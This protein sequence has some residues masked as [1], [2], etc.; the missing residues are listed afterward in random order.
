M[1]Q[2][3]WPTCFP[4]RLLVAVSSIADGTM[5][6]RAVGIHNESITTNRTEFVANVGL[7]Y[8]DVVFQRIMYG[9]DQTYDTIAHVGEGDTTKYAS[10]VAADALLCEE[11]NVGLFLPVADCVATII[12]DPTMKRVAL[13]HLG[14]HSTLAG[15]MYKTLDAMK[16]SG[17]NPTELLIWFGPSVQKESYRLEYFAPE[18]DTAW[19]SFVMKKEDGM[20]IDMQGYNRTQ[21][22]TAGVDPVNIHTSLIDTAKDPDYFSHSQGDIKGRFGVLVMLRA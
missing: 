11:A 3:D 16:N 13:L 2:K 19:Q 21:A 20:Y 1:I 7:S 8:G 5:L 4:D 9:D 14:R 15:L 18:N 17:S 22:I 12:Y 6:D 10:E